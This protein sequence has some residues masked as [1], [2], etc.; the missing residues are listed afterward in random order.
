ML[1][2]QTTEIW[3]K[4]SAVLEF[5]E[6][7]K[8]ENADSA[9]S[10]ALLRFAPLCCA[11]LCCWRL[12]L[13]LCSLKSVS[14]PLYLFSLSPL[15]LSAYLSIQQS[16]NPSIRLWLSRRIAVTGSKW[17]DSFESRRP[18]CRRRIGVRLQATMNDT[19]SSYR[20]I[21]RLY[22]KS[23]SLPFSSFL[24]RS[25]EIQTS[26]KQ[27][28]TTLRSTSRSRQGARRNSWNG[29]RAY[30]LCLSIGLRRQ[31]LFRPSMHAHIGPGCCIR[32]RVIHLSN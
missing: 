25:S 32:T 3:V 20:T 10:G 31:G 19:Q 13:A 1:L 17:I 16:L 5:A 8:L 22:R 4:D 6:Q 26:D 7:I 21:I 27:R 30:S 29:S 2:R 14:Y 15:Q 28:R 24:T 18:M 12:N 9:N 23:P 11:A